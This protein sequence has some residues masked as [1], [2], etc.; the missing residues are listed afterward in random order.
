MGL[1]IDNAPIQGIPAATTTSE[2]RSW[3]LNRNL[4]NVITEDEFQQNVQMLQESSLQF[5]E[6]NNEFLQN[7]I[8]ANTY[9][10]TGFYYDGGINMGTNDGP[11]YSDTN[12]GLLNIDTAQGI[13]GSLMPHIECELPAYIF[14]IISSTLCEINLFSSEL[15]Y[16]RNGEDYYTALTSDGTP[17]S[18]SYNPDSFGTL[19]PFK[20]Q[21][22]T[23]FFSHFAQY[24]TGAGIDIIT[25][26]QEQNPANNPLSWFRNNPTMYDLFI[27]PDFDGNFMRFDATM[28]ELTRLD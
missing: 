9:F 14:P 6:T 28:L 27:S 23:N 16:N 7:S 26:T 1:N 20:E 5:E 4:P 24:G 21:N 19:P 22:S 10:Q 8:V 17:V 3:L 2:L 18:E 25:K 13:G 12:L 15:E 11:T